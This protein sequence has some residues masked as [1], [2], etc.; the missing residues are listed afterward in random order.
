MKLNFM[1]AQFLKT[2]IFAALISV[3]TS[4]KSQTWD[5]IISGLPITSGNN[6]LLPSCYEILP[7]NNQTILAT[8]SSGIF[9]S[10]NYGNNWLSVNAL[11]SN[12]FKKVGNNRILAFGLGGILGPAVSKSDNGGLSWTAS[13]SGIAPSASGNVSVEDGSVTQNGK[14]YVVTRQNAGVYSS[15]DNGDT[16]VENAVN[17]SSALWSVL[18]IDN[19]TIIV[20]ASNGIYRSTNGGTTFTQVLNLSSGSSYVMCLKK[21][22][23]GTIYAGLVTGVI[24]KSTDNGLTWTTTSLSGSSS[25]TY[26][27]EF[28]A[29][30]NIYV[31][32]FLGGVVKFNSSEVVQG[33]IGYAANGLVNTRIV[34]LAIDE[35]GAT[36]I[37]YTSSWNTTGLGG[38]MYRSGLSTSVGLSEKDFLTDVSLYPNPAQESMQLKGINFNTPLH[39]KIK[40]I[41]GKVM[42]NEILLQP[43]VDITCLNP[44]IY[45]IELTDKMGHTRSTKFIKE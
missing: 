11:G 24:R 9:R 31:C 10:T 29:S 38:C 8:T 28:D 41:D 4:V 3:S 14:I 26:D 32:S 34:D 44:G 35:T 7:V 15:T 43:V 6:N 27:I 5:S 36:P 21:N 20:G 18:A 42:K 19:N 33:I 39:Y 30:N 25:S 1:K 12:G 22:S 40:S 37:M 45:F 16:W 23:L 2:T 17:V 13:F